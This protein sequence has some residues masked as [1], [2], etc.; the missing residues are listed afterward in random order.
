MPAFRNPAPCDDH[1]RLP[2]PAPQDAV[3]ATASARVMPD[4]STDPA[5]AIQ[6]ILRAGQALATGVADLL[7]SKRAAAARLPLPGG[8]AAARVQREFLERHAALWMEMVH[9]NDGKGSNPAGLPPVTDRRFSAPEWSDSPHFDYL[10]R[11]YLLNVQFLDRMAELAAPADERSRRRLRFVMRQLADAMAPSNFAASSPEIIRTAIETKGASLGA[12]IRNL[13]ADL[14]R[15]RLSMTDESAFEVGGNLAVTPGAVVFENTLI[16]LIQYAPLTTSVARRPLLI[17]PP[18]INK[19]YVL[20]LRPENSLVRFLVEQGHTVFMLSWRNVGGDL[21]HLG[22]DDYLELGPLAAIRVVREI[23]RVDELNV[24]G[25]CIGGT[26][27][28]SAL[29]C[30]AARGDTPAASLTLLTTLLDFSEAGE[31]GCFVDEAAVAAREAQIG[32]GG[33]L[34]GAELATVFSSLRANDLV[35]PYVVGNYLKGR[36]PPAFDILY[37]NG[38]STNLPGPFLTWYLRNTYLENRLRVPGAL[39]VCGQACDLGRLTMPAYLFATR[40]DHIVPWQGAYLSR[41]VLG[42]PT[43]FVLGASG[44]IAGV[45]NPPAQNR[46]SYW[47]NDAAAETAQ[48][49]LQGASEQGGSW[50]KH[51]GAWLDGHRG[52][53]RRAPRGLGSARHRPIEPAPGRYVK[54]RV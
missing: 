37:W 53:S 26:L 2:S 52:G 28:A 40:E 51:W 36:T 15:G 4:A 48:R 31:L 47:T 23:L 17:V 42:G 46:R 27:A 32:A 16:Q 9:R 13:I 12:G 3:S 44:H 49:W 39:R 14:A 25:F 24:L 30:A 21:G 34:H 43:T 11:A 10:R 5:Q 35:W 8:E 22:W 45:I 54:E 50:W 6:D 29:A 20:D 41:G 33:L 18:C 1:A 38:D 19:Y 7:A